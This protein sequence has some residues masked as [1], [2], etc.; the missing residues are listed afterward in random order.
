[1]ACREHSSASWL[2]RWPLREERNVLFIHFSDMKRDHEASIRRMAGFLNVD[3][4]DDQWRAILEYTSFPWMKRNEDKFEARTAGK[5]PILKSG[6]MLRKGEAGKAKSDGMTDD[7]SRHLRELGGQICPDAAAVN[8][9]YEGGKLPDRPPGRCTPE[10]L[11]IGGLVLDLGFH[12]DRCS[13]PIV[14]R[15]ALS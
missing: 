13:L 8:W 9:L 1:M 14:G 11:T 6:A 12:A 2:P 5:V 4:S 3:P 7:I 10:L 15:I